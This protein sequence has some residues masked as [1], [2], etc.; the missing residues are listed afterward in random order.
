MSKKLRL[1][2]MAVTTLAVTAILIY[3]LFLPYY[4]AELIMQDEPPSYIP[5]K[6]KIQL[7]RIHKP[8]NKYAGQLFKVTD[9]LDLSLDLIL[10]IIDSVNPDQVM[11]V[12]YK[13]ENKHIENS[14]EVFNLI[15]E[16]IEIK[17]ID[18]SL[19]KKVFLSHATPAKINRILRYAET[20]DLIANLAP[21]TAK[22]IA[23]QLVKKH[24]AQRNIQKESRT[25]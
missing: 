8:M 9:S 12:Y 24:Y 20:H 6:Y 4:L 3:K 14:E 17:Q 11:D 15:K 25:M 2:L 7:E 1:G 5:E 21:A 13:V 22:R 16:N 23:K 18:I 19:Y 10:E